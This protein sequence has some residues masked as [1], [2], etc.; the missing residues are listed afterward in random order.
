MRAALF[1]LLFVLA[2]TTMAAMGMRIWQLLFQPL[3]S[4][5]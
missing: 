5:G 2:A 1:V 4:S 3:L